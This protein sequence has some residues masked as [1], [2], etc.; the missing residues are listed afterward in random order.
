[1]EEGAFKSAHR[2]QQL[3]IVPPTLDA[4]L[5]EI[6]ERAGWSTYTLSQA[7]AICVAMDLS[8]G[9]SSF[10]TTS[11]AD[12]SRLLWNH[13][14][15]IED[16]WHQNANQFEPKDFWVGYAWTSPGGANISGEFLELIAAI[17]RLGDV[18]SISFVNLKQSIIDMR[19][20]ASLWGVDLGAAWVNEA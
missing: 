18:R 14:G 13:V 4:N 11:F 8:R 3:P 9:N 16:Y 17:R 12:A 15:T 1:M 10:R 7:F 6:K 19:A 5:A 2:R 20:R